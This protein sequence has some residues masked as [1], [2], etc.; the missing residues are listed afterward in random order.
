M[1]LYWRGIVHDMSKF[2]PSE[3]FAYAFYFNISD[4]YELEF[5]TAWL[6]H[7]HRNK[8]HWQYWILKEDSGC[9]KC[10]PIP[11]KYLEEMVCD[12]IGAGKAITG[13][14]NLKE[15]YTSNKENILMHST[16]KIII[17]TIIYGD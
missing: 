3:F 14:N 4:K 12:W 11:I 5:D 13:K 16:S 9:I 8:H 6:H 17:D 2:L 7:Q 10:I 1:G 15:W